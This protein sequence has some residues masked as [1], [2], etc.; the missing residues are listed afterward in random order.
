MNAELPRGKADDWR[1]EADAHPTPPGSARRR[2]VD[3]EQSL[4]GRAGIRGL[5]KR[6]ASA[7]VPRL[8]LAARV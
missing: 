4:G 1:V 8:T 2:Q 3:G 7:E 5:V 6:Q